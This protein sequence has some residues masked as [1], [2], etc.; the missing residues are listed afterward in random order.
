MKKEIM[1]YI[2]LMVHTKILDM[3]LVLLL[4]MVVQVV[5]T[6]APIAKKLFKFI[7]DRHELREQTRKQNLV[8]T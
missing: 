8:T 5:L 3:L 1:L 4:N 7:I 2:L 6:A